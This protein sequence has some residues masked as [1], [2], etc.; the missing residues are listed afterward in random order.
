MK[1][2]QFIT[3]LMGAGKS[4]K[5]IEDFNLYLKE[6]RNS[7]ILTLSFSKKNFEMTTVESRNSTKASAIAISISNQDRIDKYLLKQM[8]INADVVLIDEVQFL[9]VDLLMYIYELASEKLQIRFYGLSHT[10]TGELF[11]ASEKLLEIIP[12][13]SVEVFGIF[14][15]I[16]ECLNIASWNARYINGQIVKTGETFLEAKSTYLAVCDKHFN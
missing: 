14:C 5:L 10:F 2:V 9:S 8:I 3:G 16:P 6:N 11:E 7:L 12:M 4:K 15:E 1:N 13:S